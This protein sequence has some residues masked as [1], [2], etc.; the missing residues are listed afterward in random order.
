VIILQHKNRQGALRGSLDWRNA[1]D[2]T[3]DL[4]A[5]VEGIRTLKTIERR[6]GDEEQ[7]VR[8][9][10]QNVPVLTGCGMP[11]LELERVGGNLPGQTKTHYCA[12]RLAE[13][14]AE[15]PDISQSK[16]AK[17]LCIDRGNRSFRNA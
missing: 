3:I 13:L 5:D 9:R 12:D 1:A 17:A 8:F 4:D 11:R 15:D 16:A 2:G 10:F 14:L 7:E 6:D